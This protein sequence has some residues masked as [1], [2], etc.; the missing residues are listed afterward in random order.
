MKFLA[1]E[2]LCIL[3]IAFGVGLELG[4]GW[5]LVAAGVLGLVLVVAAQLPAPSEVTDARTPV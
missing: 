1:L 2:V 5:G 4:R 3:L